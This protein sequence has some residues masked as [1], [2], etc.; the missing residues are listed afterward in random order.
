M[1]KRGKKEQ[2]KC[3]SESKKVRKITTAQIGSDVKPNRI[4]LI[5]K[6]LWPPFTVCKITQTESTNTRTLVKANFSAQVGPYNGPLWEQ[7]I[8]FQ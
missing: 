5:V 7:N 8:M 1:S 6:I 4:Q 3:E 2:R